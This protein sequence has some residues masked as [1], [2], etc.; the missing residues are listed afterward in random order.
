MSNKLHIP[1]TELWDD[2]RVPGLPI[3]S[4]NPRNNGVI[5]AG[6]DK[7]TM[8]GCWP[9]DGAK[10]GTDALVDDYWHLDLSRPGASDILARRVCDA[11]SIPC[12]WGASW[13]YGK[14]SWRDTDWFAWSF[15]DDSRSAGYYSARNLPALA[16]LDPT[17]DTRLDWGNLGSP[18][19]VDLAALGVVA[20]HLSKEM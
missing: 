11:M 4:R 9:G 1:L 18:R 14:D 15:D 12:S 10:G 8:F 3:C 19:V 20:Q 13:G 17:D 7:G 16:D 2:I 5:L 6:V